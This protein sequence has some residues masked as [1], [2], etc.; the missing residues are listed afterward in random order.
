MKLL[1]ILGSDDTYELLS[2]YIRPLGFS[3]IRYRH[4]IKAMDNIDEADPAAI[5][6]SARDFPRHW[7]ALV[8]FVRSERSKE[9]CPIIILQG[10][11]LPPEISTQA[12]YLGVNGIVDETLNTSELDRLQSILSRYIPVNEKRRARRFPAADWNRFGLLLENPI[13]KTL[14]SGEVKTISHTGVSFVPKDPAMMKDIT[15]NTVLNGCSL[16]AGETILSPICC[17]VRPGFP[18][19]LEFISFPP[20]EYKLL[21]EYLETMPQ[22]ELQA[23]LYPWDVHRFKTGTA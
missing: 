22:K 14:I 19:S 20:D 9:A 4:V 11:T 23:R 16:R 7:K 17:M 10:E 8:Q 12:V 15:L 1:L 3:L 18:V 2:L 5:I 6:I 13:D 21:Q